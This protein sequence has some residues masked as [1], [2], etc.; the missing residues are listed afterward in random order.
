MGGSLT[1]M[2]VLSTRSVYM[3]YLYRNFII[4]GFFNTFPHFLPLCHSMSG[5]TLCSI[6]FSIGYLIYAP[7]YTHIRGDRLND[8]GELGNMFGAK[9][10]SLR[11]H[12]WTRKRPLERGP[13]YDPIAG[14]LCCL[15]TRLAYVAK[16]QCHGQMMS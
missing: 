11:T 13:G 12:V 5:I 14:V 2:F 8:R 3:I 6:S 16:R 10:G 1:Y 9:H 7:S 15:V 4:R